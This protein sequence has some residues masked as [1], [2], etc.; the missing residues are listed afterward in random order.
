MKSFFLE[1]FSLT[2]QTAII[3]GGA[4]GLG[5]Y[6]SQALAQAGAQVYV[7]SRTTKGWTQL[8]EKIEQAGGKVRFLQQDLTA[9]NAAKNIV[10]GCLNEFG[11]I[12]IL[13]NN[14]GLQYV[15]T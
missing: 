2:E 4:N 10:D 7:V 13:V 3:T 12:D 14:A 1:Q 6:Y 9:K 11:K 15:M 5:Q 8:R